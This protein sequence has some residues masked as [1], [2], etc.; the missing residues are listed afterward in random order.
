[1]KNITEVT[2]E[3]AIVHLVDSKKKL[4]TLSSRELSMKGNSEIAFYFSEHIRKSL[5]D[6]SARTAKF[7]VSSKV[8]PMATNAVNNPKGFLKNSQDIAQ[9]LFDSSDRR[10]S[11]GAVA[12]CLFCSS[13]HQSEQKYL[14]IL[15][16]DPADGFHP[17]EKKDNDGSIYVIFEKVE[18]V[19]PS[20]GEKLLKCA[21]ISPGDDDDDSEFDLVVLDRQKSTSMEPAQFFI[22]TFLGAEFV[23]SSE[24]MTRKFY[25]TSIQAIEKLRPTIGHAKADSVRKAVDAAVSSSVE[26][27][28]VQWVGNLTLNNKAKDQFL[29]DLQSQIPDNSFQIDQIVAEKLTKKKVFKGAYGFKLSIDSDHLSKVVKSRTSHVGYEEIILNIPD[30][31]EVEK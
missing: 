10:I 5:N 28:V 21:F 13:T 17:V 26:V 18:K 7:K 9:Y 24:D 19:V 6:P 8:K 27:D 3:K 30:F 29:K 22:D 14:S 12:I 4:I 23:G 11:T 1:M 15:K 20:T 31:K 16:L 25:T 2:I